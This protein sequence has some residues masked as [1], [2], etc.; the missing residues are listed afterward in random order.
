MNEEFA[1]DAIARRQGGAAA[2]QREA[3][4]QLVCPPVLNLLPVSSA[5]LSYR[6]N[7]PHE[8]C[9]NFTASWQFTALQLALRWF[10]CRKERSA[11]ETIACGIEARLMWD[12]VRVTCSHYLIC[13]APATTHQSM[14]RPMQAEEKTVAF[15]SLPAA[16]V[17]SAEIGG[18]L[19]HK[20]GM[21]HS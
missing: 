12:R 17:P 11:F 7:Q 21:R 6:S 2:E 10:C 5:T 15:A 18:P 16:P 3:E 13:A 14:A 19:Q 4:R 8:L 20:H 9:L 1:S